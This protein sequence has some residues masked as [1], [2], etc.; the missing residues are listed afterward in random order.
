MKRIVVEQGQ[1]LD[2]VVRDHYGTATGTLEAVLD[3]NP[4]LAR[5][6]PV[7]DVRRAVL[8]PDMPPS[9]TGKR[10]IKLWD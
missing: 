1:V 3:A 10:P 5:M 7:F 6:G 9:A 8:M 4:D 2:K